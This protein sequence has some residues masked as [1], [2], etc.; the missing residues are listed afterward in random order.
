[1]DILKQRRLSYAT[2]GFRGA[3]REWVYIN[4]EI[5]LDANDINLDIFESITLVDVLE[6]VVVSAVEEIGVAVQV[7][8]EAIV[9]DTAQDIQ[10][11][12]DCQ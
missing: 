12:I 7:V 10:I 6:G 9:V 1:M 3:I 11:N 2:R 5:S 8:Q 4:E